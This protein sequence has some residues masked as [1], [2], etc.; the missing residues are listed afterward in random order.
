MIA[1]GTLGNPRKL[2]CPGDE[3][4][5][6]KNSLVD[7]DEWVGKNIMVVGGSDSAVEVV[8]ALCKP[9]RRQQGLVLDPRREARGHQAEEP[10][11]DRGRARRRPVPDPLRD[12]G[13]RGH[14][15]PGIALT[16]K[17]DNRREDLPERRRVRD[18]RRQLAAEVAAA[19]RHPVRRQAAQLVA[20]AHRSPRR[21]RPPRACSCNACSAARSR[22]AAAIT[23]LSGTGI[24]DP[25]G[26]HS[27][28]CEREI[29]RG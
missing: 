26:E 28:G 19:D 4:E 25:S 10:Q 22:N 7:P 2:G 15:R 12:R 5:K 1:I 3:L 14:R 21:R 24:D 29:S 20:A 8:L 9:E 6:V 18:D 11:A 16:Y 13:R 23:E 17:E 27:M